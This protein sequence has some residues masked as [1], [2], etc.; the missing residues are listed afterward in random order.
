MSI[1]S[2]FT[3]AFGRSLELFELGLLFRLFSRRRA[4]IIRSAA[5]AKTVAPR[6][7]DRYRHI[8]IGAMTKFIFPRF[9]AILCEKVR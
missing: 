6:E 3:F 8:P 1:R 9:G 7:C 2:A 4:L 5:T